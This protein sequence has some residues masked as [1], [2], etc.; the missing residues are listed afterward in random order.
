M[1]RV[2]GYLGALTVA[3]LFGLWFTLDKILLTYLHPFALAALIYLV[4]GATLFIIYISPLHPKLLQILHRNTLVESDITRKDY[5]I[6]FLSAIFGSVIAPSLYLNGLNQITAVNA[7]L[8]ANS[9]VLFIIIIGIFFLN[10]KVNRK[11]ILALTCLLTGTVFLSVNN[12]QNIAFNP[13]IYGNFLVIASAF[14]WSLDTSISKFL[15][16]KRDIIYITALKSIIGGSILLII[17]L[18]IG[19]NFTLPLNQIP[20]LLFIA[21]FCLC[22]SLV[23]VYFAI[24]EIGST[25]TGSIYALSSLF[26]A[27]MAFLILK[28]PFTV[29]QIFFG[30]LMLMGVYILYKNQDKT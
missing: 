3:V 6:L 27:I 1:D 26:G 5:L 20:I 14:F 12:F 10:E 9:E 22:F 25:R 11:D 28:E 16:N 15:S 19:L 18:I 29:Y 2:W 13:N 24:R 7:A 8:L 17:S 23:L 4:G 30:L 21:M